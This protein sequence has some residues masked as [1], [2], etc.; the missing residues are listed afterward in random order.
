MDKKRCIS[1]LVVKRLIKYHKYLGD[2]LNRGVSSVSSELIGRKTG[3][4]PTVVRQDLSIFGAFGQPGCGYNVE[5]LYNQIAEILNTKSE[6]KAVIIGAGNIGQAIANYKSFLNLGIEIVGIFEANKN[7]V[8]LRVGDIPVY[9]IA[10]LKRFLMSNNVRIG[11]ICV[12]DESAQ[13]VCDDLV[14]QGV[15]GIWNFASIDLKVPEGVAI[16][17]VHLFSS[18]LTLSY[19]LSSNREELPIRKLG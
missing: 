7:M 4:T 15:K 6:K 8:G 2:I 14:S 5:K 19:L 18:L 10:Y 9:D 11:V 16:E 3:I 17:N 1:M 13:E 12:P